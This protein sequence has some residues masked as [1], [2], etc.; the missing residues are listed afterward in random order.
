MV[1]PGP[2][3]TQPRELPWEPLPPS[4]LNLAE[5]GTHGSERWRRAAARPWHWITCTCS[6]AVSGS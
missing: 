3:G 5:L 2:S 6:S 4:P 1:R